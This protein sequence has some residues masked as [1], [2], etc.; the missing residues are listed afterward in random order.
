MKLPKGWVETGFGKGSKRV[1]GR[2][3]GDISEGLLDITENGDLIR[4]FVF[5]DD[6]I[7]FPFL[8]EMYISLISLL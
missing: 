7:D 6:A 4:S 5:K 3:V 1:V 8:F 2:S